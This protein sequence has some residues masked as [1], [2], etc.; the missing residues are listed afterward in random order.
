MPGAQFSQGFR[1][2]PVAKGSPKALVALLRHPG[3]SI[4][5][6]ASVAARWALSVPAAAFIGFEDIERADQASD[7][8]R[9]TIVDPGSGAEPEL[10]DGAARSLAPLV[11]QELRARRLDASHLVLVG[12]GSGGTLA[13]HLVL[14][15]GWSCAGVLAFAP[16]PTD[17]PPRTVR[18]NHKIR[19]IDSVSN[20]SG[21]HAGARDVVSSGHVGLHPNFLP[22]STHGATV[23]EVIANTTALWPDA[24]SFRSHCFYDDT[25]MLRKMAERGFRYDSNLFAFL[26][27]ML[28]PL[29]TVAGT[30]RLPVFWEDDVHSGERL[31]WELGALR[32]AFRG[33]GLKIVNVHPAFS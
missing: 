25:R 30:V 7:A 21:A 12:F 6:V 10:L 13:L 2:N 26:Q 23:D 14:R 16:T 4:E 3:T 5:T 27:P 17:P 28:A 33:P 1:L 22:G 19:L 31:L 24:I 20:S 18:R 8:V 32:A 9:Q 11:T 15:Q 29:R